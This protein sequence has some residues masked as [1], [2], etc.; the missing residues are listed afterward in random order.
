MNT[1]IWPLDKLIP[2][3]HNPRKNDQAV[4]AMAQAIRAFGFRVP[5]LVRSNGE[6]IDG[7]LRLKAARVAG[8]IEVPVILADDM[9]EAQVKAFRISVNRMAELAEWDMDQLKLELEDLHILEF[10][11]QLTG[12]DGLTLDK[13]LGQIEE[14]AGLTDPDS[15]PD[16]PAEPVTQTGDLWALG[17]HRLL[18]GD[19]TSVHCVQRLLGGGVR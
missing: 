9:T 6:I 19:S 5:V 17:H 4:E 8:L 16:P 1:E 12:L 10:D 14:T 7:H 18:C 11:L 13:L 3:A 2:Y 15:V